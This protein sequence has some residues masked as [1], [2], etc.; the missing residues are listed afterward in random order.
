[1]T[2]HKAGALKHWIYAFAEKTHYLFVIS[3]RKVPGETASHFP[4]KL[5]GCSLG[6]LCTFSLQYAQVRSLGRNGSR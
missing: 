6:C 2:T 5:L 3:R 1:M 4:D